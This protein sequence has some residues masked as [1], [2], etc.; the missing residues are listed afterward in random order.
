[1]DDLIP[2]RLTATTH[3]EGCF[4][5]QNL[6]AGTKIGKKHS[7][8]KPFLS[9]KSIGPQLL[10]AKKKWEKWEKWKKE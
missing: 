1:M 8:G 6:Q 10:L 4:V 2:L 7:K 3:L 9:T 5:C